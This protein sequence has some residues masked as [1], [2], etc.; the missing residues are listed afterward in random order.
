MADEA[1]SGLDTQTLAHVFEHIE[2]A[3]VV[4]T[5][6]REVV[7]MN[8]AARTLFRYSSEEIYHQSTALLYADQDDFIRLGQE[9]FNTNADDTNEPY[10]VRYI[11]AAGESFQGQT[12]GGLIKNAQGTPIFFVAIIQDDSARLAAEETLNRLHLITSSRQLAFQ[13]RIEAILELGTSYFGLPIGIFSK[14]SGDQYMIQQV[15]HPENAL[16]AGMTFELGI[17]YC[18]LVYQANDV[19]GFS[20][21]SES[22]IVTHPCFEN[23][24]LE[25][26]LGVPIFVDGE[27]YG[28]LNFSSICPTRQFIRQDIEILRLLAEWVGHEVALEQDFKAL[29]TAHDQM[30]VLANTDSLTGLASRSCIEQALQD[31]ITFALKYS[32][33]LT[34]AMM[35]FDHFKSINDRFGHQVGD[36]VLACFGE[37]VSVM[38]RKGDFYGRWGGE[39]F[40]VLFPDTHMAGVCIALNRLMDSLKRTDLSEKY[41]G[42]TLTLSIGVTAMSLSDHPQSI[43]QRADQLLY[44]AKALGRDQIQHD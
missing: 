15:I 35:D 5:L 17:T 2:M 30:E 10:V 34:V 40:I 36:E 8:A 12:S 23:F 3:V 31:Q 44:Q 39:E 26:Y 38:G 22:E 24:G 21:V 37:L 4:A 16:E 18:S 13:E 1:L 14:I 9:R 41:S 33:N 25:A 6:G 19:Q 28:T 43:V 11:N 7:C 32:K 20:H 27:R 42:L 29:E